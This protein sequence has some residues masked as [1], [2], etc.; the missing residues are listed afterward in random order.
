MNNQ[1]PKLNPNLQKMHQQNKIVDAEEF[2]DP[3]NIEAPPKLAPL[4]NTEK[5]KG[6]AINLAAI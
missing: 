2:T 5:E 4:L 3:L 6:A 1:N